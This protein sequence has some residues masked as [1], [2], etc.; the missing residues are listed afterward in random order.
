[1]GKYKLSHVESL[2]LEGDKQKIKDA[3]Y[4]EMLERLK[5]LYGV[6]SI[7]SETNNLPQFIINEL[8][9]SYKLIEEVTQI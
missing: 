2:I 1:M 5:E 6:V 8:E 3:K 4:N 7:Y 9:K